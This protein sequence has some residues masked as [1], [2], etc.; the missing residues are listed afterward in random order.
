MPAPA[1][2]TS[3]L[4]R[5]PVVEYPEEP[6]YPPSASSSSSSSTTTAPY[7]SSAPEHPTFWLYGPGVN[8]ERESFDVECLRLQAEAVFA[9]IETRTRWLDTAE[10][11]PG[12][13]LP[14]LLPGCSALRMRGGACRPQAGADPCALVC[15]SCAVFPSCSHLAGSA[16]AQRRPPACWCDIGLDRKER[17][18]RNRI[19]AR[20]GEGWLHGRRRGQGCRRWCCC[21]CRKDGSAGECVSAGADIYELGGEQTAA[22]PGAAP[23]QRV[24]NKS[25]PD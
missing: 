14:S 21:W 18:E 24:C 10:G 25:V 12:G 1:F 7:S 22:C 15:A 9:G 17:P 3:I 16:L 19:A 23:R 2:I 6:C 5:F 20:Q 13:A 8:N 11:A 4:S